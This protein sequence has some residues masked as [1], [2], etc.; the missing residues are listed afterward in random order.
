MDS[1]NVHPR[2]V[3]GKNE[4]IEGKMRTATVLKMWYPQRLLNRNQFQFKKVS[5]DAFVFGVPFVIMYVQN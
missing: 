3:C 4:Y 1:P 5:H 2:F